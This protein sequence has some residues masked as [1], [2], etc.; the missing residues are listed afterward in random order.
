VKENTTDQLHVVVAQADGALG[1]LTYNREGLG[2]NIVER[3]A[4]RQALA[5]L[6]GLGLQLSVAQRL[7]LWRLS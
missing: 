6:I 1:R 7:E 4:V 3:L 2:Q 5:E